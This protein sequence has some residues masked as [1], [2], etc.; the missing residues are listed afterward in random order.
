MTKTRKKSRFLGFLKWTG[1]TV[2]A[3]AGFALVLNLTTGMH[4][5]ITGGLWPQ[6]DFHD[7]DR[8]YR[9][10]EAHRERS[11]D[12]VPASSPAP[13]E[14]AAEE[15]EDEAVSEAAPPEPPEPDEATDVGDTPTDGDIPTVAELEPPAAPAPSLGS[16]PYYRGLHM[17]GRYPEPINTA[18]P[19]EG[20]PELWRVPVGGGYASFVVGDGLAY[21]IEQRRE[22]EV[23][24][25][26][27]LLT[28]AERWSASWNA[29][30]E[31]SMGGD[32]PRA[33]PA[34][35]GGTLVAL[36][37][38]GELHALDAATGASIWRTNILEESGA[39]N[40]TWGMAAS[41]AIL[42][43]AVLTAPGGPNGAVI[44]YELE[45]GAIRW[46]ALDAQGAYTA[47]AVFTLDGLSQIVLIGADQ[48][49]SLSPDGSETYW[50]RPWATMNGINAAQPL[51]V[52][53]N[54]I[55]VSSGYGHGA[56]VLGVEADLEA[57]TAQVR[58]IWFN[59]RM[60]NTFSTSVFHDGYVYGLDAGILACVDA[61]NGDRMWKGG[62]YGHGQLLIAS[63]HLVITTERGQ[64]VL[65]RA[66]PE[67]HQEIAALPAVSGRTW[68]NPAIA[69]GILLVRNDREAVAFDLRPQT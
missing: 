26:Y 46:R 68:N 50:S 51:Q 69:E 34:L 22:Q 16:W 54:R 65:V 36:G 11:A 56:A 39:A 19:D 37:A 23:V 1:I 32:G 7:E 4:L 6:L 67:S 64:L 24:A 17:D 44:A 48:V 58:E 30:F 3:L 60:K 61:E 31:E 66:T 12:I 20:P 52:A 8:H 21:T 13:L 33:T 59:N 53:P 27:D 10:I 62:R 18:W 63:G 29:R 15:P 47:P 38:T 25:A 41:P 35:Y 14:S 9:T 49:I 5:Q 40:L 42:D 45:T 55:F 28:G 43:G 57:N 2:A